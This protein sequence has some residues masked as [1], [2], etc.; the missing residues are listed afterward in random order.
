VPA[1]MMSGTAAFTLGVRM[2]RLT[3]VA[4]MSRAA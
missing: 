3:T 4:M 2:V 1:T